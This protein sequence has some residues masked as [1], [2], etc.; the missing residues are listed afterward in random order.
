MTSIDAVVGQ[1]VHQMRRARHVTL[2]QLEAATGISNSQLSKLERGQVRW[3]LQHLEAVA[4]CL[5]VQVRDLLPGADA[6]TSQI[7]DASR[8][9]DL[10]PEV[11]AL[12]AL[13]EQHALELERLAGALRQM[14]G[15][16]G[17]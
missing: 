4:S 2:T 11:A 16:G 14:A 12:R 3:M 9:P 15:G 6:G 1:I 13:A 7:D 8:L 10:P 17:G 5:G